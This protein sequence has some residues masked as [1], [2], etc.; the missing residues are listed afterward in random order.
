MKNIKKLP[1]SSPPFAHPNDS[2]KHSTAAFSAGYRRLLGLEKAGCSDKLDRIEAA[3]SRRLVPDQLLA[4]SPRVRRRGH[5]AASRLLEA[6][7]VRQMRQDEPAKWFSLTLLDS[8]FNTLEYVPSINLRALKARFD[9]AIRSTGLDAFCVVEVQALSNVPRRG[10]GGTLMFHVHAIAWTSDLTAKP[11]T[12]EA[13]LLKSKTLRLFGLEARTAN[14]R[15]IESAEALARTCAYL[16]KAPDAAKFISPTSKGSWEL[17]K[18]KLPNH[19]RLRLMECLSQLPLTTIIWG[20][21]GGAELVRATRRRLKSWHAR[22][23]QVPTG[24]LR[25]AWADYWQRSRQRI[26]R[27]SFD[28]TCPWPNEHPTAWEQRALAWQK[29]ADKRLEDSTSS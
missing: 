21:G 25:A 16:F 27:A 3:V 29:A 20:V 15:R 7:W 22:Q 13:A 24:D 8:R 18:D 1:Q 17:R 6:E 12:I 26:A 2:V 28:F 11:K 5:A 9:R 4:S 14:V 19:L 10:D 23:E